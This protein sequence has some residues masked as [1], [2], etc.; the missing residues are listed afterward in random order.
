MFTKDQIASMTSALP[1]N[2]ELTALIKK[3]GDILK[4]LIDLF[5]DLAEGLTKEFRGYTPV[6]MD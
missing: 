2:D 3:I 5:K 1:T 6:E 4:G